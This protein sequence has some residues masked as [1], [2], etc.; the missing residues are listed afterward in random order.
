MLLSRR[1][2]E[3]EKIEYLKDGM[4]PEQAKQMRSKWIKIYDL[5]GSVV[6]AIVLI[7]LIF[8]F[9][10]RPTYVDGTSMIP[11]LNDR[12]WLVTV[13]QKEYKYGDIVIVTQPNIFNEPLIKRIIATEGQ[14]IDINFENGEVKVDGKILNEPYI[15]ELTKKSE[16]NAFP[17]VVP[18][19]CIFVMGDNRMNSTD[20]RSPYVGFIDVRYILGKAKFRVLPFGSFNIYDNF[21]TAGEENG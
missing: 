20:S 21:V 11:T 10:C 4:T 1:I 5:I 17:L 9:V 18:K 2:V 15:A 8:T 3:E 16:G 14:V 13:A 7:F 6:T 12:D 19:G